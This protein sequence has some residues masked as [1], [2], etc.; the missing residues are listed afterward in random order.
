MTEQMTTR[1]CKDRGCTDLV[2][3]PGEFG[4]RCRLTDQVPRHMP[5][6]PKDALSL[7]KKEGVRS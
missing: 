5:G 4:Y 3:V 7:Q 2:L 6:C 1:A